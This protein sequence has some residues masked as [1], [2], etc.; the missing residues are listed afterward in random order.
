MGRNSIYRPVGTIEPIRFP[1][2]PSRAKKK[3]LSLRLKP[4][5]QEKASWKYGL[6]KRLEGLMVA[7]NISLHPRSPNTSSQA[8]PNFRC[9]CLPSAGQQTAHVHR[10]ILHKTPLVLSEIPLDLRRLWVHFP[11]KTSERA[12]KSRPYHATHCIPVAGASPAERAKPW[13]LLRTSWRA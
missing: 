5:Q 10:H 8:S 3:D 7:T 11:T 2:L 13:P 12:R 4:P 6:A 1:I 9:R